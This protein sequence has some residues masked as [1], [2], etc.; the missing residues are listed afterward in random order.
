MKTILNTKIYLLT[1][2]LSFAIAP[3]FSQVDDDFDR[4]KKE[5]ESFPGSGK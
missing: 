4:M 2:F 1:F 3:A 5:F